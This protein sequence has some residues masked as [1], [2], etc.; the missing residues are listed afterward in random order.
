M[1]HC[2]QM[3]HSQRRAPQLLSYAAGARELLL[4]QRP[5]VSL[6]RDVVEKFYPL[7]ADVILE[8]SVS[9]ANASPSR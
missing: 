8:V 1:R 3:A 9:G 4:E 6:N 5:V 2:V 7:L